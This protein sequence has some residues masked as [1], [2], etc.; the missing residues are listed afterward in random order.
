MARVV[1][2]D[3]RQECQQ[4]QKLLHIHEVGVLPAK[5]CTTLSLLGVTYTKKAS[6]LPDAGQSSSHDREVAWFHSGWG[7]INR[8]WATF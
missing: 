5:Q 8:R 3:L 2:R 4:D 7:G 6:E 1:K